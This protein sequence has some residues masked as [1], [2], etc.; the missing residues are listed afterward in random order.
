MAESRNPESLSETIAF[1]TTTFTTGSTFP[2][3]PGCWPFRRPNPGIRNPCRKRLHSL[4]K[5]LPHS[6]LVRPRRAVGRSG[7]RIQGSGIPVGNDC[8]LHSSFYYGVNFSDPGGLS[9]VPAADSRDPESLSGAI[10]FFTKNFTTEST[11]PAQAGCRPF[12][13]SDPRIRNPC[14][15]RSHSL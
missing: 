4:L 11:F 9:A 8:I 7:G 13:R 6:Q 15:K 10:V 1:F 3:P 5:L 14:R 12:R 2:Q